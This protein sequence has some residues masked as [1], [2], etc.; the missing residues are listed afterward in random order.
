M[1][2]FLEIT[3]NLTF[4]ECYAAL[5]TRSWPAFIKMLE[6]SDAREGARAFV[7]NREPEWKG[8]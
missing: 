4:E 2:E 8:I 6:S 5:R 3:K 7:E 1:S